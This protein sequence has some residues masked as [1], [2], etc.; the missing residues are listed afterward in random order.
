VDTTLDSE[1]STFPLNATIRL[2]FGHDTGD[3]T[4]IQ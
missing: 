4:L 1:P 2:D 3:F